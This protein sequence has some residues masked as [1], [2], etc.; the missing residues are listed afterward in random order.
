MK[1]KIAQNRMKDYESQRDKLL[2]LSISLLFVVMLE[3]LCLL[4]KN[5]RIII[6]PPEVKREFWAQGNRFSPEYLEEQAAYMASLAL[7]VNQ[8][9]YA[10]NTEIL[11]RYADVN[12]YSYL[13]EKFEKYQKLL[14]QNNASTRFDIKKVRVVPNRNKVYL[15]GIMNNFVGTK[16]INTTRENYAVEFKIQR[17]RLFLKDFKLIEEE[18]NVK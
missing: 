2:V 18:T 17:G 1:F 15:T 7:N 16:C 12:T 5:E 13:R 9:S 3:T 8:E 4:L 11:M 14:K 10:Y 6:L